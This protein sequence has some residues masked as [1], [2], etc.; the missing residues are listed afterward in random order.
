MSYM[1]HKSNMNGNRFEVD[2][3]M[4]EWTFEDVT[5][6]VTFFR[7]ARAGFVGLLRLHTRSEYLL[8]RQRLGP[9]HNPDDAVSGF[10]LPDIYHHVRS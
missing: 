1:Y 4:L 8:W 9:S 7:K 5:D 6:S 3:A 10:L 2:D